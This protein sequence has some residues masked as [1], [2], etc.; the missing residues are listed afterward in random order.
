MGAGPG[1]RQAG[2]WAGPYSDRDYVGADP[3]VRPS[4]YFDRALMAASSCVTSRSSC[5]TTARTVSGLLRSTPPRCSSGIGWSLPPDLSKPETV[6]AVVDQ[7]DKLVTQLEAA[8]AAL[9]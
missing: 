4:P 6:R 9:G 1:V 3:R 2:T 8:I 5:A 7:L